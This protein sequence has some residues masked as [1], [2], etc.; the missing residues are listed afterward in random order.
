MTRN[1]SARDLGECSA[2]NTRETIILYPHTRVGNASVPRTVQ[3]LNAFDLGQ[4]IVAPGKT[5]S[6][7]ANTTD[8]VPMVRQWHLDF[9]STLANLQP[10]QWHR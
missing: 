5:L 10:S 1:I 6:A 9:T 2:K 4:S 7:S 8:L 3:P